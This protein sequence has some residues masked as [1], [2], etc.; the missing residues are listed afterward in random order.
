[1]PSRPKRLRDLNQLAKAIVDIA[2]GQIPDTVP[3]RSPANEF[4]RKGGLKGELRERRSFLQSAE[5]KSR[6]S[7]LGRVGMMTNNIHKQIFSERLQIANTRLRAI[8]EVEKYLNGRTL[9]TFFTSF[10]HTVDIDSN[11]CDMLQSVLQH[12]DLGK[13]LALMINSPGGDGLAAERI[14]ATCRAYSGTGDYWAIVPGRAKSA[15][16]SLAWGQAVF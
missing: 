6:G 15:A 3:S 9:V 16:R 12:I 5:R 7:L 13:G 14:V 2:T 11:D 10:N 4:A 8:E 1:M